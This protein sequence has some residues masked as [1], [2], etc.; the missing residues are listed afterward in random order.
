MINQVKLY[1]ELTFPFYFCFRDY[2]GIISD[3]IYS[4]NN[5]NI[6]HYEILVHRTNSKKKKYGDAKRNFMRH[7]LIQIK[8]KCAKIHYCLHLNVG[9]LNCLYFPFKD[10]NFSKKTLTN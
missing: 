8:K 10:H 7:F 5:Y 4:T 1:A 3:Y 9:N 6:F 2:G